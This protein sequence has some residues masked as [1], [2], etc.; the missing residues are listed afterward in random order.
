M[1][2]A[3]QIGPRIRTIR[4][5]K[6]IR[7]RPLGRDIGISHTALSRIERGINI[8]TLATLERV[9]SGLNIKL[10]EFFEESKK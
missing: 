7:L 9:A 1:S 3:E 2:I 5:G 8:P 10:A 6:N 4:K